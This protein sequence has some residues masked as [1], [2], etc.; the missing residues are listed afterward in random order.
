MSNLDINQLKKILNSNQ[1][2][3]DYYKNV[4]YSCFLETGTYWGTTMWALQP[5]FNRLI[6]IE[7]SEYHYQYCNSIIEQKNLNN[8]QLY[9][10]DSSIIIEQI[11]PNIKE[12]I[13]FF[14][15]SHYSADDTAKGKKDVPLLEELKAIDK[16]NNDDII[17]IDD[18]R[19]FGKVIATDKNDNVDWSQVTEESVIKCFNS[20]KIFKTLIIDDRFCIFLR[21]HY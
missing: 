21:S 3:K 10:G 18:H 5:Y 19:L 13:I 17:I 15:D 2:I 4:K 7:L 8:I 14:L 11:L 1:D 6:S 16:R 9:N 20:K 12:N